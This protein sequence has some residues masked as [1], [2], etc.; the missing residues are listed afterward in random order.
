[1]AV[2]ADAVIA[3]IYPTGLTGVAPRDIRAGMNGILCA[4]H[5]P[6]LVKAGDCVAVVAIVTG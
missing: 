3:R 2:T 6:G 4:R 5:F 1:E